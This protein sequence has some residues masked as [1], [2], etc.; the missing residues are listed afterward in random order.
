MKFP[1]SSTIC[2]SLPKWQL[3]PKLAETCSNF[4]KAIR[5]R[6]LEV[7]SFVYPGNKLLLTAKTLKNKKVIKLGL[8]VLWRKDNAPLASSTNLELSKFLL[9]KRRVNFGKKKI[10][11]IK[12]NHETIT[13]VPTE[14]NI[15]F[16]NLLAFCR[17]C[18]K[19]KQNPTSKFT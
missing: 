12:N 1:S 13:F 4:C 10:Q 14:K 5:L 3:L 7:F 11:K 6:P 2:Q 15:Y 19:N 16:E 9:R 18:K 8:L 17:L